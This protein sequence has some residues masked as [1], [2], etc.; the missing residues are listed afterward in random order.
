MGAGSSTASENG[1]AGSKAE[2]RSCTT[3]FSVYLGALGVASGVGEETSDA[4]LKEGKNSKNGVKKS[5]SKSRLTKQSSGSG[6]HSSRRGKSSRDLHRSGSSRDKSRSGKDRRRG[7]RSGRSGRDRDRKGG[8]SRSSSK[9]DL[10]GDSGAAGAEDDHEEVLARSVTQR[11]LGRR[12][13]FGPASTFSHLNYREMHEAGPDAVDEN[14]V[15]AMLNPSTADEKRPPLDR[16]IS[17][18]IQAS[19]RH[20]AHGKVN[21]KTGSYAGLPE[22]WLDKLRQFGAPL[23]ELETVQKDAYPGRV[24]R[25]LWNMKNYLDRNNGYAKEGVFRV[26]P[27]KEDADVI[28]ERI[29]KG[30]F[31]FERDRVDTHIM[32]LLIKVFFKELPFPLLNAVSPDE[33]VE[34]ADTEDLAAQ[35]IHG[36]PEPHLST[37]LCLLDICVNTIKHEDTNRMTARSLGV[38]ISPNL[39]KM[40]E[41]LPDPMMG[42][43]YS[44]KVARFMMMAINARSNNKLNIVSLK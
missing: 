14:D 39:F 21:V 29:N 17:L 23:E 33:L 9:R 16:R 10:G 26:S 38:V 11:K 32:A 24:P 19:T 35:L 4:D 7:S 44:K 22:E 20:L 13:S 8:S 37:L 15:S 40:P 31:N 34:H 18:P 43:V 5:S 3:N 27:S 1:G 42:I 28:K 36:L 30:Q 6:R 25:V 41:D 12:S 2:G